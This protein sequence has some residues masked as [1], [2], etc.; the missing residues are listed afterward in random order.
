MSTY[1][2]G[3]AS[4]RRNN[5]GYR[6]CGGMLLCPVR[7]VSACLDAIAYRGNSSSNTLRYLASAMSRKLSLILVP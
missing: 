7:T 1:Q 6:N 3:T 2:T 4:R 5:G